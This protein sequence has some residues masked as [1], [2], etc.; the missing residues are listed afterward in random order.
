MVKE[1]GKI[2]SRRKYIHNIGVF[3]ADPGDWSILRWLSSSA[4]NGTFDGHEDIPSHGED[5]DMAGPPPITVGPCADA[6][7][8]VFE[9]CRALCPLP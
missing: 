9:Q 6:R 3:L 2:W 1:T 7:G 8:K 4:Q 5:Q